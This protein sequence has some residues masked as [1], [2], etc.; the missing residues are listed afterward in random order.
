MK[1]RFESDLAYQNAAIRSV[2]DLFEGQPLATGDWEPRVHGGFSDTGFGFA[3]HLTLSHQA[4]L[5]NLRRVQDTNDVRPQPPAADQLHVTPRTAGDPHAEDGIPHFTVEMETGTG[6]TYVYLRTIYELHRQYGWTKFI[7]VVPSVAVREGV[8]ANLGLLAEHFTDL[9][10]RVPMQSWVYQSR[11]ISRLRQF[12]TSHHLQILILNIDAFNKA[13]NVLHSTDRDLPGVDR[14]IEFLQQ[15]RPVVVVDEPQNM[16]SDNARAAIASLAP[17]CTLRYSATH[18][19]AYNLIYKLGPVQAYDHRPRLVK[20]IEV[21]SVLEQPD[22]NTPYIE[23]LSVRTQ[24]HGTPTARVRLDVQQPTGPKRS[25]MTLRKNGDDLLERSRGRTPYTG[26]VVEEINAAVGFVSFT[27]GTRIS[28]GTAVGARTDDVMRV[29]VY[30]TVRAHLEKEALVHTLPADRQLKVL[31]LFFID[32]VA[33]YAPADGK[34]RQWFIDAYTKLSQHA[35]FRHLSLPSVDRVHNGYFA[36]DRSGAA[37][38]SRSGRTKA[39][40]DAYQLIMRDKARLLSVDEPLRF[41]FSHSA[42]REGWD[43]PNVFQICTL[44]ETRSE[45]K[46]RQEI[47]RGLRLPVMVTGERCWDETVNRLTIIANESYE[48]FARK[49]QTEVADDC[50]QSFAGRVRRKR[51]RPPT[52]TDRLDADFQA[53]WQALQHRTRYAVDLDTDS[54]VAHAVATLSTMAPIRSPTVVVER[55]T[56]GLNQ[57][58][59]TTRVRSRETIQTAPTNRAVP[60]LLAHLQR[61]TPLTRN[62]LARVMI[63]SGRLDEVSRN[64]QQF[65][66][67]AARAIH[68]ALH[69]QLYHGVYFARLPCSSDEDDAPRYEQRRSP[70]PGDAPVLLSEVTN[71]PGRSAIQPRIE[72]CVKLPD[73]F[74]VP[75]PAGDLAPTWAV[76]LADAE[77]VYF[78]RESILPKTQSKR[79]VLQVEYRGVTYA[80]DVPPASTER[81]IEA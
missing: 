80:L 7:I 29:Q 4:L 42:L 57:G 58:G 10:G 35:S 60:D 16:E 6:K 37:K 63:E 51:D 13:T 39:D 46:K 15:A 9:Y 56:L 50:G 18:R 33:H 67:Q 8:Q 55:A 3:N 1:L 40:D 77:R 34:I 79:P 52:P 71:A 45:L 17:M 21:D 65:I 19:E 41:I 24:K 26:W 36:T 14:P 31:S 44:N 61:R 30:Q 38:D 68:Q 81:T 12:A 72:R 48:D 74:R 43:N 5:D 23:V 66:D 53:I 32:R 73:W 69:S 22:F 75:T 70:P 76:V 28:V 27:N 54:L 11:D 47:G 20:Q 78:V 49:L 62:T 64:P 2:V 25:T 59:T